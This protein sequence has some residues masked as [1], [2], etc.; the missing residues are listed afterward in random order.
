[1]DAYDTMIEVQ[2][3]GVVGSAVAQRVDPPAVDENVVKLVLWTCRVIPSP[4]PT[5]QMGK[6]RLCWT[7]VVLHAQVDQSITI[8]IC[9]ITVTVHPDNFRMSM[10]TV[11]TYSDV[12][13]SNNKTDV[14]SLELL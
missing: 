4:Q 10:M 2:F 3:N 9:L 1:M 8:I 7:K 12:K 6:S 11:C 5:M 14:M 13:I